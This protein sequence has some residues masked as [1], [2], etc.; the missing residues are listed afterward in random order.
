MKQYSNGLLYLERARD[1]LQSVVTA[2]H[3]QL[4]NVQVGI[5][6]LKKNLNI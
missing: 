5:E 1:I 3:P 4:E 2:N 6:T